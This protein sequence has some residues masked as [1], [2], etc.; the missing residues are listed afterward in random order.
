VFHQS[1]LVKDS[2]NVVCD[3][4]CGKNARLVRFQIF[5]DHDSILN[6]KAILCE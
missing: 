5:V 1:A 2:I 3:I 6:G 4:A